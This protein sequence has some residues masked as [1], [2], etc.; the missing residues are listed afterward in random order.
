MLRDAKVIRR[1]R[2]RCRCQWWNYIRM[3][4]DSCIFW[5]AC[6]HGSACLWFA[7]ITANFLTRVAGLLLWLSSSCIW[8]LIS[9][10]DRRLTELNWIDRPIGSQT[11]L[12]RAFPGQLL[13]LRPATWWP[14]WISFVRLHVH[15]WR[16]QRIHQFK[17]IQLDHFDQ[18]GPAIGHLSRDFQ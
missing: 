9:F 14:A 18:S 5:L 16:M 6:L 10:S 4:M 3:K 2:N 11:L 17:S 8:L 13:H 12:F 1:C 15:H 7:I